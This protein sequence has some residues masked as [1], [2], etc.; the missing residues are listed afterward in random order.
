MNDPGGDGHA[1]GVG[2]SWI[3]MDVISVNDL[4]G[5]SRDEH[6]MVSFGKGIVR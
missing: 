5:L 1:G 3:G 4:D 2:V 6:C